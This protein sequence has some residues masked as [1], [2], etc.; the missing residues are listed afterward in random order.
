MKHLSILVGMA[1]IAS[2][3]AISAQAASLNGTKW[4]TVDDKTGQKK[5]VVQF[6]ES[7]GVVSGK[8]IKVYD[9]AKAD[10]VCVKCKGSLK[11][12]PVVGLPI[13]TGLKLKKDNEWD[14]GQ[15]VDP[16]SGK[17]Y[18]GKA[19][20][21]NDGKTLELRGYVGVSALGRSQTWQRVN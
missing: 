2:L 21:S 19:T 5:A 18:K 8:I 11:D 16:E 10:R 1:V 12:K 4:N 3:T 13:I 9:P 20:L 6:T 14:G 7:D 15:L 17:V